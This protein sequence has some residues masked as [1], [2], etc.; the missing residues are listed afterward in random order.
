LSKAQEDV[1]AQLGCLQSLLRLH[2]IRG[3]N[4][5]EQDTL[6]SYHKRKL[7]A[8]D[9]VLAAATEDGERLGRL[10]RGGAPEEGL[11]DDDDEEEEMEEEEE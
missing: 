3:S 10:A 6:Q 9:T 8:F 2:R 5:K 4:K 11:L 1:P 7:G